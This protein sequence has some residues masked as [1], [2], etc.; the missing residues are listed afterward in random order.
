MRRSPMRVLLAE[1]HPLISYLMVGMLE[2]LGHEVV[3]V[4]DGCEAK[5]CLLRGE[6]FNVIITDN[7]MPGMNGVDL[8]LWFVTVFEVTRKTKVI[9]SSG[10]DSP[11]IGELCD[12]YADVFSLPKPVDVGRL[13]AHL[14]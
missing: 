10:Y 9:I 12:K 1:D 14:S 4:W 5:A 13:E 6:V 3:A 8:V 7:E 2:S 11:R